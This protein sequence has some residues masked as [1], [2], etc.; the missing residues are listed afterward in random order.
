MSWTC[1]QVEASLSE[2]LDGLLGEGA[3]REFDAHAN[4]CALCGPLVARVSGVVSGMRQLEPIEEPPGL[5]SLILDN[6]LGP[7]KQKL[8]W[9][10][11]FEW[12]RPLGQPRFAYGVMSVAVTLAV[13]LPSL[14]IN[15]RRVRLSDFRPA[16]LYR[17]ADRQAHLVY[18]RG[19]KFVGDL[20]VVYEIQS[21]LRPEAESDAGQENKRRRQNSPD[22]PGTPPGTTHGPQKLPR[23]FNHAGQLHPEL[24][25]L[26]SALSSA[27]QRSLP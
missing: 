24:T 1:E 5:A 13:L 12:L 18:A 16:N 14:G 8:S 4:H 26:A 15:W 3:R 7:R 17:A 19:S 10:R 22:S 9:R 23:E 2:Y 21:R 11:V 20:R 6:T 25:L 27:R